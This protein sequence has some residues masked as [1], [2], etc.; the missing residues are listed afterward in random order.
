MDLDEMVS[1]ST[2][3]VF[4]GSKL[5]VDSGSKQVPLSNLTAFHGPSAVVLDIKRFFPTKNL[6]ESFLP[7]SLWRDGTKCHMYVHLKCGDANPQF[8]DGIRSRSG[9]LVQERRLRG[10]CG[11]HY[12]QGRY[13]VL[14]RFQKHLSYQILRY[15]VLIWNEIVQCSLTCSA[16]QTETT[17]PTQRQ[18]RILLFYRTN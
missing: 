10:S 7:L 5:N 13:Y 3:R 12:T 1:L 9:I 17:P 18:R 16:S 6:T 15:I 11:E 4:N 14:L 2:I 8:C